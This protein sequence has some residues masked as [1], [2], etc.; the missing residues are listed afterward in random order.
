MAEQHLA[1]PTT[2]GPADRVGQGSDSGSGPRFA[3]DTNACGAVEVQWNVGVRE[4]LPRWPTNVSIA[5]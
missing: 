3:D 4:I 1:A 5:L 2:Q